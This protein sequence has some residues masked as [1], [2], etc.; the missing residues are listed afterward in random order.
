[1]NVRRC[2]A[3]QPAAYSRA[4]GMLQSTSSAFLVIAAARLVYLTA[5][6][7]VF[8][9]NMRG[10]GAEGVVSERNADAPRASEMWFGCEDIP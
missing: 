6:P 8:S 2:L 7:T 1:M 4:R 5:R 9:A 3:S 10:R